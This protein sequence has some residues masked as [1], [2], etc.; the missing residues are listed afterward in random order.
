[1]ENCSIKAYGY[2]D[3]H[4]TRFRHIHF[5]TGIDEL[6]KEYKNHILDQILHRLFLRHNWDCGLYCRLETVNSL[7]VYK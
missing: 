7:M 5:I 2:C 4:L 1:M 6:A 3:L